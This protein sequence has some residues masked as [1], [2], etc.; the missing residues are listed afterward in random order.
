MTPLLGEM[1]NGSTPAILNS[2][3]QDSLAQLSGNS[4][5]APDEIKLF[6][7]FLATVEE[8]LLKMEGTI[9]TASKQQ[10]YIKRV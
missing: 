3:D 6:K 8:K 1:V 9:T 2:A 7:M 5:L 4:E 10:S